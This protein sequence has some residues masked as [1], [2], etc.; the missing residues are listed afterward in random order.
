MRSGALTRLHDAHQGLSSTLQRARR[1]LY[2]PKLQDDITQK[3]GR[4]SE[5]QRHGNKKP[6]PPERQFLATRPLKTLGMALVEFQ[7]QIVLVT[8]DY[9]SGFLTYDTL[10]GES[11]EAVT[12]GIQ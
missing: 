2:W 3:V 4:C 9:F 5:C 7:N 8:V 10:D 6:R 1:T 11:T 12:Q